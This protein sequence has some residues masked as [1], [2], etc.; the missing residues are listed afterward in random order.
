MN[1]LTTLIL[2]T[3]I[4]ILVIQFNEYQDIENKE[5]KISFFDFLNKQLYSLVK[6]YTQKNVSNDTP[7]LIENKSNINL[8]SGEDLDS[9][10]KFIKTQFN[11]STIMIPKQIAYTVENNVIHMNNIKI[12]QIQGENRKEH[13]VTLTFIENSND[14]FISEWQLLNINGIFKMT[15]ETNRV[16][17]DSPIEKVIEINTNNS[18]VFI[19]E[20]IVL[21]SDIEQ[22]SIEN[23]TESTVDSIIIP[24][25]L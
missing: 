15:K 22:F 20:M 18:E 13:N 25:L 21:S 11:D 5:N 4:L 8:L 3:I 19:P 17:F 7:T 2:L 10:L 24:S 14:M 6:K 9:V 23:T 16:H 1:I 12:I